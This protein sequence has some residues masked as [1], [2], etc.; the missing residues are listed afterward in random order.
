MM[1]LRRVKM[2]TCCFHDTTLDVF[3]ASYLQCKT[4]EANLRHDTFWLISYIQDHS[5][6][7]NI[8]ALYDFNQCSDSKLHCTDIRR[9]FCEIKQLISNIKLHFLFPSNVD[10]LH[11]YNYNKNR[12]PLD[13]KILFYDSIWVCV[14]CK[15]CSYVENS[16]TTI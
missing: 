12:A 10:I 5:K 7:V 1:S 6:I 8:N 13:I 15:I 16:E 3:L 14:Y 2:K 11:H 9:V 4:K